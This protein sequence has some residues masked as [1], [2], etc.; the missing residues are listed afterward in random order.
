M[1]KLIA[2][3]VGDDTRVIMLEECIVDMLGYQVPSNN[4]P[5]KGLSIY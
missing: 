4:K 5:Y 1:N 2:I 3:D